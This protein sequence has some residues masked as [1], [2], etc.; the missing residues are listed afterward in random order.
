MKKLENLNKEKFLLDPQKMGQLIGGTITTQNTESH[1]QYNNEL[2]W[3]SAD[4]VVNYSGPDVING[5]VQDTY[6]YWGDN[7]VAI[8]D[9]RHN[10]SSGGFY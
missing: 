8:R 9:A 4:F 5:V 2:G 7:D 10:A 6:L 1:M 3:N